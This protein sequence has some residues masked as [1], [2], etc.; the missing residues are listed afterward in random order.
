MSVQN[1]YGYVL[2]DRPCEGVHRRTSF[3]RLTLLLQQCPA[4]IICLIR[5][6]LEMGGRW[7]Y[8][9]CFVGYC[10]Q[11]LFRIVRGILVKLPLSF[12]SSQRPCGASIL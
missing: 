2:A 10:F 4:C 6:V 11:D 5:V 9:C 12:F 7:P 1:C 3:M 8:N